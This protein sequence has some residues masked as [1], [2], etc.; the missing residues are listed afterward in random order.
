MQANGKVFKKVDTRINNTN[1]TSTTSSSTVTT[2]NIP[3]LTQ[4]IYGAY[5]WQTYEE[6][7]ERVTNFANGLLN[8]GLG[9]DVC[10]FMA[11]CLCVCVF[12]FEYM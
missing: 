10:F 9:S 3:L 4:S 1:T 7:A 12:S 6:V 8:L 2:T 11:V 5:H